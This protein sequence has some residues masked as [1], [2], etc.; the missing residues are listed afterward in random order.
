[1]K[2][3]NIGKVAKKSLITPL[4]TGEEVTLQPLFADEDRG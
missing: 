1:M 2:V 3:V 4:F